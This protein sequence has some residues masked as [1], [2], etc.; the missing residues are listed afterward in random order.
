MRPVRTGMVASRP[1]TDTP[2]TNT[3]PPC[4]FASSVGEAH[5]SGGG[6]E[7]GRAA[8]GVD[9]D[10]VIGPRHRE[11]PI[12]SE[13]L[14]R[15]ESRR[16]SAS[17]M[18]AP[19]GAAFHDGAVLRLELVEQIVDG[20]DRR[21]DRRINDGGAYQGEA[22]GSNFTSPLAAEGSLIFASF[23]TANCTHSSSCMAWH[24]AQSA[25]PVK[26]C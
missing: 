20:P 2:S 5:R 12:S 22:C 9:D 7:Q 10:V 19:R 8:L 11:M 17:V 24:R 4:V 1:V 23:T 25:R 14:A 21:G 18:S 15:M 6:L 3:L 26:P 16:S 13:S